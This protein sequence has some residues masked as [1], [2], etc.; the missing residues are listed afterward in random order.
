MGFFAPNGRSPGLIVIR[1]SQDSAASDGSRTKIQS[2]RL[3]RLAGRRVLD[4]RPV[5][6]RQRPAPRR[7]SQCEVSPTDRLH[8]PLSEESDSSKSNRSLDNLEL[9]HSLILRHSPR[10]AEVS[11]SSIS[12]NNDPNSLDDNEDPIDQIPQEIILQVPPLP[13]NPPPLEG[14]EGFLQNGAQLNLQD[15]FQQADFR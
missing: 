5:S 8:L 3:G 7:D 14:Q 9:G 10:G 4:K 1:H 11:V 13:V 12:C 2:L 15:D 6:D